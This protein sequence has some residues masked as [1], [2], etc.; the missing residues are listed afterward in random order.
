MYHL[1]QLLQFVLFCSVVSRKVQS[2]IVVLDNC[3]FSQTVGKIIAFL[4]LPRGCAL[5][6]VFGLGM[7]FDPSDTDGFGSFCF[8]Q[9]FELL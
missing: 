6:D 2:I 3:P 8:D 5:F 7:P 9:F 1:N 4:V